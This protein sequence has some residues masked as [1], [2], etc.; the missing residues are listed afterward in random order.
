[1]VESMIQPVLLKNSIERH[2]NGNAKHVDSHSVC[3]NAYHSSDE[4]VEKPELHRET[5][6]DTSHLDEST[7]SAKSLIDEIESK[8]KA[9][10][11]HN[12]QVHSNSIELESVIRNSASATIPTELDFN[13][14][15]MPMES[16]SVPAISFE[17]PTVS[18]D[19]STHASTEFDVHRENCELKQHLADMKQELNR[20]KEETAQKEEE[21][22]ANV[23]KLKRELHRSKKLIKKLQTKKLADMESNFMA[24]LDFLE[25]KLTELYTAAVDGGIL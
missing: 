15:A 13:C 16:L 10:I 9:A 12:H 6:H 14:S 1:M 19:E 2:K 3:N 8:I 21:Y 23:V 17:G 22:N 20:V 25:A 24:S 5:T 11:N 4:I 18:F 7:T